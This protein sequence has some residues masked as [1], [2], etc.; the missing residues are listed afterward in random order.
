MPAAQT[1]S[2][3]AAAATSTATKPNNTNKFPAKDELGQDVQ[4]TLPLGKDKMERGVLVKS[5]K[6]KPTF[7]W[8]DVVEALDDDHGDAVPNLV[9]YYLD[10]D[11][12]EEK[13][14]QIVTEVETAFALSFPG[15]E[16]ADIVLVN[17]VDGK[18]WY[19][20]IPTPF[21]NVQAEHIIAAAI[22][23]EWSAGD[24]SLTSPIFVGLPTGEMYHPLSFQRVPK[25]LKSE[26][27]DSLPGYVANFEGGKANKLVDVWERQS[28]EAE[29][30]EWKFDGTIIAV[31]HVQGEVLEH[32]DL[33][34]IVHRWPGWY[35]F[36]DEYLIRINYCNRF[37]YCGFCRHTAQDAKGPN[38]RHKKDACIRVICAR[39]GHCGHDISLDKNK[40]GA[41]GPN[42]RKC[43]EAKKEREE[44]RKKQKPADE[45]E[46]EEAAEKQ[47]NGGTS[48]RTVQDDMV[49][50][51]VTNA[52]S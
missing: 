34:D 25:A 24:V 3:E 48:E 9:T 28:K 20:D 51:A 52:T 26:F 6:G 4:Y 17:A 18:A 37:E 30:E 33:E 14:A 47:S 44:A 13:R 35:H 40:N 5:C 10:K 15:K 50:V 41:E 1:N 21:D 27:I 7:N 29:G 16:R 42:K 12:N 38:R 8:A 11:L 49:E 36:Q 43:E 23:H 32:K 45:Q 31:V 22:R 46:G 39:C 2:T 19:L